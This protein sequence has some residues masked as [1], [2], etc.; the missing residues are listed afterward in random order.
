MLKWCVECTDS[1][2]T[3]VVLRRKGKKYRERES[4]WA[5]SRGR[6]AKYTGGSDN[7]EL[8]VKESE[9]GGMR[10]E[11]GGEESQWWS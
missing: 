6:R 5:R 9:S 1:V 11:C 4:P 3:R 7:A 8:E 2:A 10:I